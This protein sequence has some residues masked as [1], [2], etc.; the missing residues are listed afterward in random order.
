MPSTIT[1]VKRLVKGSALTATEMDTN[2]QNLSDG[3]TGDYTKFLVAHDANGAVKTAEGTVNG[4]ALSDATVGYDKLSTLF[5]ATDSNADVNQITVSLDGLTAAPAIGSVIYIKVNGTNTD[6]VTMNVTTGSVTTQG[7]IKKNGTTANLVSG[8]LQNNQII[9]VAYAGSN[10]FHLLSNLSVSDPGIVKIATVES[11]SSSHASASDRSQITS[12]SLASNSYSRIIMK[13][14]V[15][16]IAGYNVDLTAQFYKGTVGVAPSYEMPQMQVPAGKA[17][18]DSTG[19]ASTDIKYAPWQTLVAEFDGGNTQTET[20][21][22]YKEGTSND[23]KA[24]LDF[25]EVYGVI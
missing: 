18:S 19:T 2:L 8:D 22:L 25:L 16:M 24:E 1:L 14:T 6:S 12:Y 4:S 20:I 13:A 15:R 23:Y 5:Y 11:D 17:Y 7:P 10:T 21:Y 3:I 9:A